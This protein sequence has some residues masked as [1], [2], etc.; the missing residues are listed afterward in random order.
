MDASAHPKAV[1]NHGLL[2]LI[3]PELD[4][5]EGET[6][7]REGC[8]SVP[9]LTGSV[10][11]AARLRLRAMD[12][13]GQPWEWRLEGFEAVVAQHEVDH[14]EGTLFLDRVASSADVFRRKTYR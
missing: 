2:V 1:V 3:D 12:Q 9:D 8:L 5:P 11:R 14:L 13:D 10:R 7:G 6:V 4:E